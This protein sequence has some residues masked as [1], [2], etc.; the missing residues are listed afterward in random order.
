MTGP[1]REPFG[2]RLA[3]AMVARGPLCVGIDPHP[4]L[5]AAWGLDDDVAG[6][7]RFARTVV[8]ALGDQVAVL[9]PQCAFFERHGSRGVAVLEQV[10]AEAAQAGALTIADAKRGDIG[11]TMTAYAQA[12]VGEGSPLAADAVTASPYLGFESLRPLL[13]LAAANGRGV[14]VLALTSNPEGPALQL[15]TTA[16]GRSVAQTILDA[17]S[18]QNRGSAGLGSSGLGSSGLSSTRLGSVGVVVGATAGSAASGLRVDVG[19]PVLAPGIGA[20]GAGP[21]QL[22]ALFPHSLSAVLPSSSREVLGAGPTPAGLRR[23][24][25]AC[26][27]QVRDALTTPV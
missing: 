18:E 1:A 22:R 2:T 15:A 16:D 6:L 17:V 10:L 9:K 26:L 7:E 20:Q 19:G 27:E 4:Q 13:D 25:Q 14:F 24:A 8:E 3:A 11:S 12:F 23:A 21:E 5:L